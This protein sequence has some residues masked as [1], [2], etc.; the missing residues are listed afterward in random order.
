[1]NIIELF[2]GVVGFFIGVSAFPILCYGVGRSTPTVLAE[3]VA[4]IL[5]KVTRLAMGPSTLHQK[6]DDTYALRPVGDE[7]EFN[8]DTP[9]KWTHWAMARFGFSYDSTEDAW[10]TLL[11]T[12]DLRDLAALDSQAD[13]PFHA[14]EAE[15]NRGGVQWYVN[16]EADGMRVR[17]GAALNRLKGPSNLDIA[18]EALSEGLKEHGGDT[19]NMGMKWMAGGFMF[20]FVMSAGIS[21]VVMF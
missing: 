21:Y 8:Y 10:G 5:F 3:P 16:S 19:S 4:N 2:V 1:M 17:L 12:V 6:D 9:R 14:A 15:L 7:A 20:L 11:S 13:F 18:T